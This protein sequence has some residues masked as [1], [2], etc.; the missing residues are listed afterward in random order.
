MIQLLVIYPNEM[1]T[2]FHTKICTQMFTAALYVTATTWAEPKCPSVGE[3][4][5]NCGTSLHTMKY[6]SVIKTN[7]LAS[8][9]KKQRTLKC[10]L[11]RE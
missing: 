1:K 3:W 4:I 2:Y 6:Y 9:R 10:T 5:K 7:E 8:Q 11:P